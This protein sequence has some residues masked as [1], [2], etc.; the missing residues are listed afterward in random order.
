MSIAWISDGVI[1]RSSGADVRLPAGTWAAFTNYHGGWLLSG[2]HLVQLDGEGRPTEVASTGGRIVVSGDG[3]QTAFFADGSVRVGITSGM[4]EGENTISVTSPDETG[5]V[6]FLSSG[7]VVYNGLKG[8]VLLLDP[9]GGSSSVGGL[10]RADASTEF[11]NL[12][13][14]TTVND[15]GTAAV[16]SAS[17]GKILWTK[18]RWSVG[19]FSPDGRYVAAYRSATGGE[20]ETIGILDARTGHVVATNADTAGVGALPETPT[21]WDDDGSLLV[22]YRD[23]GAWTVLRLETNGTMTRATKVFEG[24]PSEAGLVFSARP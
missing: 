24:D 8:Q 21:A 17:T 2:D 23:G 10:A 19:T 1:H 15:D 6:G 16:L 11:G 5:P 18:A 4:G 14:G 7:R 9:S 22:P 20:F 13:A 12:I 3:T